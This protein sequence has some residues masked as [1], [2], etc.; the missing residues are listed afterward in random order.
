[1]PVAEYQALWYGRRNFRAMPERRFLIPLN[2][3][4]VNI[5]IYKKLS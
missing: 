5:F 1:M 3:N 4:G 2:C